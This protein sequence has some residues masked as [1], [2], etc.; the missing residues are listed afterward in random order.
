M[1]AQLRPVGSP[2]PDT[3]VTQPAQGLWMLPHSYPKT[4]DSTQVG[5]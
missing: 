5:P 2:P 1:M 3:P 4:Q